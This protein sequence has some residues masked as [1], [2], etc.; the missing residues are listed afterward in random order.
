MTDTLDA[1]KAALT[2]CDP[3]A[4]VTI[5]LNSQTITLSANL[6]DQALGVTVNVGGQTTLYIAYTTDAVN[7][8][9]APATTAPILR[10]MPHGTPLDVLTPAE[11]HIANGHHWQYV[12]TFDGAFGWCAGE[13]LS[14]SKPSPQ[15]RIGLHILE[16]DRDAVR[17]YIAAGAIPAGVTVLD[18]P[19]MAA[20]LIR[21]GVQYVI[22][23]KFGADAETINVPPDAAAAI[24]FGRQF[25]SEKIAGWDGF[26]AVHSIAHG[27][28]QVANEVPFADR[29]N[30]FWLGCMQEADTL[31]YKLAIGGYA[32]GQPE[33]DQWATMA[34]ALTYAKSNGH[35]VG[36]HIYCAPNTPAGELS[37]NG[38]GQYYE[39]RPQRLYAAVPVNA[40]PPLVYMEF[41]DAF[42]RGAF[43]GTEALLS[44]VGVY[45]DA[46]KDFEELVSVNCWTVGSFGGWQD[47]DIDTAL[48]ALAK[49]AKSRQVAIVPPA[50]VKM[51][52]VPY[53]SQEDPDAR[54]FRNDCGAAVA[55][56]YLDFAGKP[57]VPIDTLAAQTTLAQNDTGLS[58]AAVIALAG[59][60]GLTLTETG[61]LTID[62][63][64]SEIDGGRPPFALISYAPL[65]GRENQA[66]HGG[67]FVLI[68]GYDAA[69]VYVND[70]DW[71]ANKRD[72][73]HNWAVPSEQFAQALAQSPAP[74]QGGLYVG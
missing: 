73:G 41:A 15:N 1:L 38:Q 28:I 44:F 49:F 60:H 46:S 55:A 12:K 21:D 61:S 18:D 6:L 5:T 25:I 27:Y 57:S 62:L 59:R 31:G 7:M 50:G 70:P 29:H 71:W 9:A 19:D 30:E 10:T 37:P 40:R 14:Q 47:A 26:K 52:A 20:E 35:I 24:A 3:A 68:T 67:H 34:E 8:R 42:T 48:T 23:R 53:R 33:P 63:I 66:D 39:F 2:K 45:L 56:M 11:A 17:G 43:Q 22:L 69:N 65:T 32:I 13:Y 54:R 58:T 4:L 74:H 64:K 16:N 36:L 51:L 72:Q